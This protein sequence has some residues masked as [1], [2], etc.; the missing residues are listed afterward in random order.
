MIAG[1]INITNI[2]NIF[3]QD[4]AYKILGIIVKG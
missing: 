2:R 4:I 1:D 3:L